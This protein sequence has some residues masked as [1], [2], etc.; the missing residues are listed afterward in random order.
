M[1][2]SVTAPPPSPVDLADDPLISRIACVFGQEILFS[3]AMD[4]SDW[5]ASHA[6]SAAM[7]AWRGDVAALMTFDVIERAKAKAADTELAPT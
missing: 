6:G 3:A 2:D 1:G 7:A 5:A 4:M